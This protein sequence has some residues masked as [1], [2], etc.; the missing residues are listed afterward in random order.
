M[1]RFFVSPSFISDGKVRIEGDDVKHITKVLRLKCGDTISVCDGNKNDYICTI[2]ETLKDCVVA[3]I[4]E[5]MQNKNES[6]VCITLYQGLPKGDK[7]DYIIQKCVELGVVRIVPVAMKR[8][9]VKPSVASSKAL[10]W[11]RIALEAAKQCIRGI[12]PVVDE[13]VSFDAMLSQISQMNLAVLPYENEVDGKLK[14]VL[15][16]NKEAKD[17]AVIIGPEGGFEEEEVQNA[18]KSGAH[19]VTLGPR[20]LRCETAP[21]ATV[22]AVMYELGDW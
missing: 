11:Q 10:R 8:S 21:V 14:K 22:S 1:H 12:V 16:K 3:D 18:I 20:I 4:A 6:S 15:E 9:V 17:I 13:P 19:A 7:M 2:S 5:T